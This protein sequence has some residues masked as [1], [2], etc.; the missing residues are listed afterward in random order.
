MK[1][2]ESLGLTAD[3]VRSELGGREP[4]ETKPEAGSHKYLQ[5]EGQKRMRARLKRYAGFIYSRFLEGYSPKHIASMLGVS[6]ES[7]RSR[8]RK[9]GF[10]G[11][12]GPGRPKASD[13]TLPKH[14]CISPTSPLTR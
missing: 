2:L 14:L 13:Q 11:K 6:E 7:V 1:V 9:S 5:A 4:K 3:E 8:L 10:F 12:G